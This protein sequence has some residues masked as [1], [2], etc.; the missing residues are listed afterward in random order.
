MCSSMGAGSGSNSMSVPFEEWGPEKREMLY[1]TE[2]D[3]TRSMYGVIE[4]ETIY[5]YEPDIRPITKKE[6]LKELDAYKNDDGTYGN[7]DYYL[8]IA[9]EDGTNWDSQSDKKPKKKGAIGVSISTPD[10]Q[11]V[12]G[13]DWVGSGRDR[14]T[15]PMTTSATDDVPELTNSRYGYKAV[16]VYKQRVKTTY[17]NWDEKRQ[18]YVVKRETLRKSTTKTL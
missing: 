3:G 13:E 14:H 12:W 10:E 4:D 17:D 6:I 18:R 7:E 8:Y 11:I 16:S 1:R 9:Y 2:A 5:N 15:T